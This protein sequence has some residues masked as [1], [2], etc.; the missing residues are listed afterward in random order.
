MPSVLRSLQAEWNSMVPTAQARGIRR[1][2][3]LGGGDVNRA[4]LET[5]EYR[6]TKVEWLRSILGGS[7][8]SGL[9]GL[10]FGVE[11]EFIMPRGMTHTECARRV[12]AA[13]VACEHQMY[14]HTV[15]RGAWKVVTDGSL[16]NFTS[17]AE[18]VSPPIRGEDGFRQLRTVCD[19]LTAMG[20]KV[21]TRC[22]LHVHV[23]VGT[24]GVSFFKNLVTLYASAQDAIDTFMPASRRSSE[25]QYCS[26]VRVSRASLA[27]AVNVNQVTSA[28]GQIPSAQRD[29][30]R[31]CK[32]NL[33]SFFAYGT[34]EFRHHGG[35]VDANKAAN[36][37]R[38][39]L[40]MVLTA[41]AGEQVVSSVEELM[42]AVGADDAERAYFA[43]RVAY[44]NRD[45][46]SDNFTQYGATTAPRA[47][48]VV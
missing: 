34:V 3:I 23:G 39:C 4:P 29:G 11:L 24:E 46:V 18:L 38:L 36:W 43:S 28:I 19:T 10:S 26:P 20:A 15:P 9:E 7:S 31:Y 48:R 44:F 17:G 21:N 8:L 16:S 33:K 12:S 5:I 2:R 13:G 27:A 40:R 6:R 32:L 37:V 42:T 35:T 30:T 25:N 47:G 22:G 14:G 1:V 45:R 41:R